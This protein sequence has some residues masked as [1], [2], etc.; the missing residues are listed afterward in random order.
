[1]NKFLEIVNVVLQTFDFIFPIVNFAKW[2]E[3]TL[4]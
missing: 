2:Y 4:L 3:Q 1:M